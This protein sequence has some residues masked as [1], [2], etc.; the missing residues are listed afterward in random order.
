MEQYLL[1]DPSNLYY[2]PKRSFLYKS[3][4]PIQIWSP[5]FILANE[6][7][8]ND[9]KVLVDYWVEN[10][11]TFRK[12]PSYLRP[13]YSFNPISYESCL[14]HD[15]LVPTKNAGHPQATIPRKLA[16]LFERD[17]WPDDEKQLKISR[18]LIVWRYLNDYEA[19]PDGLEISHC[20]HD[21]TILN[22][23]AESH[24]LNESRKACHIFGWYKKR[25]SKGELLCPHRNYHVCS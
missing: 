14:F 6:F 17:Y 25:D 10:D 11:G 1:L 5:K 13:D 12:V 4:S 24:E 22:L 9:I 18:H 20:D 16:D 2:I 8:K 21:N 7:T 19:I 3:T 23:V 15:S